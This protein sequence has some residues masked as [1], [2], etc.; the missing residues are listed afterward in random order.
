MSTQDGPTPSCARR[1]RVRLSRIRTPWWVAWGM[2]GPIIY[3]FLLIGSMVL[4][5]PG[6]GGLRGYTKQWAGQ[7]ITIGEDLTVEG[8]YESF[9]AA[10]NMSGDLACVP[11]ITVDFSTEG[12]AH[13]ELETYG[14]NLK[15]DP[16]LV[17]LDNPELRVQILPPTTE[18]PETVDLE[19]LAAG[20]YSTK[21]RYW[22]NLILN[23]SVA[24]PLYYGVVCWIIAFALVVP[25]SVRLTRRRR[26]EKYH[27]PRCDYDLSGCGTHAFSEC[28]E[29][30]S[31]WDPEEMN[32]RSVA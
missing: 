27:C 17:P 1:P 28:P 24:L 25:D 6:T 10:M 30:G 8:P 22:K 3:P 15:I 19:R 9:Q 29:C 21:T 4:A 5:T 2:F 18:K 23:W 26:L 12:I 31:T 13:K 32:D 7:P 16:P 20:D 11:L 14:F